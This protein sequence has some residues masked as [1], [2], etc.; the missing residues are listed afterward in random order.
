MFCWHQLLM[1][2]K[3]KTT[4]T[5]EQ[6]QE[7]IQRIIKPQKKI[8]NTALDIEVSE[9]IKPPI[10]EDTTK[11]LIPKVSEEQKNDYIGMIEWLKAQQLSNTEINE[12][13]QVYSFNKIA[14]FTERVRQKAAGGSQTEKKAKGDKKSK[15]TRT[16][17]AGKKKQI[18]KKIKRA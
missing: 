5:R 11:I 3:N 18:F 16:R 1:I 6:P 17:K 10:E 8:T 4:T 13:I 15:M 9:D 12:I 14:R 7:P 2:Q